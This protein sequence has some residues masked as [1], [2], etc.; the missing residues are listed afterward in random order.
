MNRRDFNRLLGAGLLASATAAS[1]IPAAGAPEVSI[2]MDD[3]NLFGADSRTGEKRNESILAAF[4]AHSIKAAIFA[5]GHYVD[6]PLARTLLKRWDDEGH[7]ICNHTYSHRYYPKSDFTEYT[8]DIDRCH[9]LVKDY[10]QF[11]PLFRY[12]Y[13]KEGDTAEQRDRMRGFLR[14]RGYRN[15]AVTID[16]S[17]WYI[18]S[19]LRKRLGADPAAD[20]GGYRAYYRQHIA[21]RS[22]YYDDI[23]RRALGRS[24]RHTLLVHHNVVN[25]LFLADI[26]DQYRRL[27][28]KL[29]D[30][31]AAYSDPVYD[32]SPNVLPAGDSLVL[33]VGVENGKVKRDRWPAEDGPHEAPK[34]DALGL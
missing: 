19:R 21:D 11:R 22:A 34:M 10:R 33:A 23:S 27:G 24:V 18:D 12:P 2:T 26:L 9:A 32:A 31:E 29:I 7:I 30:A 13:L 14:E 25:E 3:F 4:R 8:A 16:A 15:G 5:C 17:D 20:T 6:T 1:A 28:W